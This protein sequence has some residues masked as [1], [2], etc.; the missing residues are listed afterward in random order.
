VREGPSRQGAVAH[1]A[2][3]S[4]QEV[5]WDGQSMLHHRL[6]QKRMKDWTGA[7]AQAV[8]PIGLGVDQLAD[9]QP[10]ARR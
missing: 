6:G 10:L 5:G 7:K 1:L 9:L 8:A 2:L 3:A 4:G